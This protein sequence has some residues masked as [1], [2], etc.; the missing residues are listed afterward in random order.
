MTRWMIKNLQASDLAKLVARQSGL[1]RQ[2]CRFHKVS[3]KLSLP[4]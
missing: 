1:W 2:E 4:T 3:Q